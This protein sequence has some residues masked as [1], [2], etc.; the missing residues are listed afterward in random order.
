MSIRTRDVEIQA[1]DG[2]MPAF[3][4]E[5]EA[6][7]THPAVIVIMEA[8]GL[9]PHMR[10]VAERIAGEGYVAIAPDFY[11]RDLPD[12]KVGYDELP[13][14]IQL[15][16]RVDDAKFTEDI[17]AT[18]GYAHSLDAVGSS[19]VGVTGFC[20]GG[21]L[22]FLTACTL[23]DEIA[24]AAPFY[25]GGIVGHLGQADAIQCPLYLFFGDLDAFIPLDQVK[26]IDAK[27][28]ELGKRYA[29]ETYAGA[30]H[31]FFCDERGEYHEKSARDAWGKLTGFLAEHLR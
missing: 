4:A 12:N 31:G 11:Y 19:K 23:P 18:I 21:R 9:V 2:A 17:R 16:T 15:M 10:S 8:F 24:A 13:K 20:M 29:V 28:G 14:A 22:T 5:P 30:N 1:A 27:L 25:G 7:G 3:I 6:A 26:E